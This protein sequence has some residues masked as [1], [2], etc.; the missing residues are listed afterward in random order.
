MEPPVAEAGDDE[1]LK[2][3]VVDETI[4]LDPQTALQQVLR[5]AMHYDGLARGLHEAVKAIDSRQ[6]HLV[7][8]STSCNEPQYTK[9]ITA[10]CQ[11]QSKPMIKVENSKLL[12]EWA[13]LCKYNTDG[14]AVKIVGCSCVVI[15]QW[16]EE[17]PARQYLLDHLKKNA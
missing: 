13:G 1:E 14:K 2:E 16:G 8:L 4:P 12:G 7:V 6:C 11:E 3:P 10:L 15:K 17:T 9:L 5:T